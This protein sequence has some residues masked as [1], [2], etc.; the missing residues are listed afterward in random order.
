MSELATYIPLASPMAILASIVFSGFWIRKQ[1]RTNYHLALRTKALAYSLY[2]NEHLR[3]A[4]IKVERAFGPLFLIKEPLPME[5][6][7]EKEN[8]ENLEDATEILP[9]IMTLLAHWE[10]MALAIHCTVADEDT[11]FEMVAS[12]MNQHI[13]VFRNFIA[14]RQEKNQRIYYHLMCLRRRWDARLSNVTITE[15]APVLGGK[16]LKKS[17]VTAPLTGMKSDK[18]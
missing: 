5:A 1:M 2:A 15:M 18:R 7:R 4:R 9:S 14:D 6:I 10:N 12:T 3:D 13:N 8:D 16:P 11:C 17:I